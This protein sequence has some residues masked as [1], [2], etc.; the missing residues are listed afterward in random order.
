MSRTMQPVSDEDLVLFHYRDQL[1][2]ERMQEVEEALFYDAGLRLRLAALRETLAAASDG[3]PQP[4]A[5]AGLEARVWERLAPAL[6]GRVAVAD[7]S[8]L[9][10]RSWFSFP[11]NSRIAF[12]SLLLAAVGIGYLLGRPAAPP[13]R[14]ALL[15]DDASRRVLASYLAAHLE[16]T[17]RALMVASNSPA[18]G[19]AASEL[20]SSLLDTNRLYA[21]A[22]ERA[23]KP[24]LGQFLRELEP[25]L[26]EL[27]NEDG[28]IADGLGDEIRRRDL[29]FKTRAAA[30]LA[31]ND[32]A[33]PPARHAL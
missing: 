1:S 27:A 3:W 8:W 28:A 26:I 2:R 16:D 21:L 24:A 4:E 11:R 15:A 12:A 10:W 7:S 29:T 14:D 13:P 30:A 17:E 25:V 33:P 22:A 32:A 6:P 19:R 20:A 5:D 18:D 9:D 31:R 23:G